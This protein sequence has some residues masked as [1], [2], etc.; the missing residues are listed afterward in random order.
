MNNENRGMRHSR[1]GLIG[2]LGKQGAD[3]NNLS[4]NFY[5]TLAQRHALDGK[6]NIFGQVLKGYD[7]LESINYNSP[8]ENIGGMDRVVNIDDTG[9][10]EDFEPEI[11]ANAK[12]P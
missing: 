9:C 6:G 12:K 10:Y 11:P 4:S 2:N 3:K 1:D 8:A 5:I 7:I